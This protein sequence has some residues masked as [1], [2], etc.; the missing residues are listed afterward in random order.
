MNAAT[1]LEAAGSEEVDK[2]CGEGVVEQ[3][4]RNETDTDND[5][6]ASYLGQQ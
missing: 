6:P 1:N 4:H 3:E 5:V 2:E